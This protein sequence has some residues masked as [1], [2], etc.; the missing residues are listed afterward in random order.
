MFEPVDLF[1]VPSL[2]VCFVQ[3]LFYHISYYNS[4]EA[5]LFSNERHKVGLDKK[6]DEKELG[7]QRKEKP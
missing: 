7:E 4:L 2:S 5:C 3:F 6:E 1:L